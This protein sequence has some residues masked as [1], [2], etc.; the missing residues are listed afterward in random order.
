MTLETGR[1]RAMEQVPAFAQ[2]QNGS[3]RAARTSCPGPRDRTGKPG[4][5]RIVAR[6]GALRDQLAHHREVVDRAGDVVGDW[7]RAVV[8]TPRIPDVPDAEAGVGQ[9]Q[10]RV[11]AGDRGQEVDPLGRAADRPDLLL[12]PPTHL[13]PGAAQG[14][15]RLHRGGVAPSRAP[16]AGRRQRPASP[17]AVNATRSAWTVSAGAAAVSGTA[18][19]AANPGA[20]KQSKAPTWPG[21]LE[22]GVANVPAASGGRG[23]GGTGRASV[24]RPGRRR[25]HPRK[26][27]RRTKTR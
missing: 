2:E 13:R 25:S 20:A 5:V 21:T 6:G 11:D 15:V 24:S 10:D 23:P 27:E 16:V 12:I 19:P 1:L 7:G 4:A 17:R 22:M 18:P 14:P 8:V 9:D 3:V 26:P